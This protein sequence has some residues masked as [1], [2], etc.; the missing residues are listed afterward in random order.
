MH[1]SYLFS[2]QVH[3]YQT[4]VHSL[5]PFIEPRTNKLIMKQKVNL[6]LGSLIPERGITRIQIKIAQNNPLS[7]QRKFTT[8]S[9]LT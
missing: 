4:Y 2:L 1:N 8:R 6:T 9:Q 5:D 3:L 7:Q